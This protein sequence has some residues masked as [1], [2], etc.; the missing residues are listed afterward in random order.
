[1]YANDDPRAA[2][3]TAIRPAAPVTA[4]GSGPIRAPQYV[5]FDSV[6]PIEISPA[7]SSTWYVRAQNFVLV[8]T[9]LRSGDTLACTSHP[10]EYV[11]IVTD[12]DASLTVEAGDDAVQTNEPALVVIPPGDSTI[13]A[14]TDLTI[15]RLFDRRIE[16]L[17][18]KAI[19]AET[20][21]T[22]D[23][24]VRALEPWPEPAGG[25]RLRVY[26]PERIP[27]QAGRFGRIFR[28]RAFMVNFLDLQEGPRDPEKLS[29]HHHDD[30][31]QCSLAVAGEYVHH[32]R[33]P[34][35][36]RRSQWHDDEHR[37]VGTP[38]VAIIPPPTVHTSEAI[39]QGANRLIDIFCPPRED[40]SAQDGWVLNA[41][42][43]P[44]P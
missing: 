20:Y 5:E 22:P 24:R 33:T 3:A 11:A 34:W 15:T 43:F 35:T 28:T 6:P 8:H 12:E 39:S 29:P 37:K 40:F 42:E 14:A 9:R 2:L 23:P 7:G 17:L 27:A 18:P 21:A 32:I 31:E 1:M 30:F 25:D 4:D 13:T 10:H 36:P 44:Q 41:E 16:Y 38:S 19:N 26:F